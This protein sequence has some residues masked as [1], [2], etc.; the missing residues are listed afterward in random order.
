ML[1]K[2]F[3]FQVQEKVGLGLQGHFTTSAVCSAK[4]WGGAGGSAVTCSLMCMFPPYV[5]SQGFVYRLSILIYS[6]N[7]CVMIPYV[8]FV[9]HIEC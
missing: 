3:Q 9:P 4:S 7:D 6:N 8:R 2:V 1:V 5:D